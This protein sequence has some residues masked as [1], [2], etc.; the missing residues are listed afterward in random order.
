M[1]DLLSN[2]FLQSSAIP[3]LIA[4]VTGFVTFRLWPAW[5]GL[6]VMAAF[7]ASAYLIAGFQFSPLTS[8]RKILL[9]GMLSLVAG[10]ALDRLPPGKR[11]INILI[12]VISAATVVWIMWPLLV[13]AQS[14]GVWWQTLAAIIYM[15]WNLVLFHRDSE[16]TIPLVSGI[17]VLAAGTGIA[18]TVA[19]TALLGQLA[20]TIAAACGALWLLLL[21]RDFRVGM[22]LSLPAVSLSALFGIAAV[23]YAR[24]PWSSLAWLALVPVLSLLP[25]MGK[26]RL[27]QAVYYILLSLLPASVAVYLA[28]KTAGDIPF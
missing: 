11:I 21:F 13:R 15:A 19:A 20:S 24:L 4:F 23:F 2:P 3:F 28:W 18:A 9:I 1:S 17:M 8:T 6:S 22:Q 27:H 26:I 5:T 12:V 25:A 7:L 16:R 10:I 14:Q